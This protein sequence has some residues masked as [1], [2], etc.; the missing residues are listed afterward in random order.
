MGP[1]EG[2]GEGVSRP[3]VA[4]V[5][6]TRPEAIKMAPVYQALARPGGRTHPRLLLTGQHTDLVDAALE[7]FG[8][9][10]DHDM[11][12]MEEGQSLYHVAA[13]CLAGL[14]EIL[15]AWHP[16]MVLVQGDTAT[17]FFAALAGYF[18]NVPTGHV[19]AGLRSGNLRSPFPEEGFR[20]LTGVLADLHFAPTSEARDNLLAEGVAADRIHVTGNPVVD[21]LQQVAR[22]AREP[23]DPALA[24][25]L[26]RGG[27]FALLTAHRRESFGEPLRR[28]FQGVLR[29]LEL[30]PELEI[31]YPVHPNPRVRQPAHELLGGHPRI[32]LVE[33]LGYEDLVLALERSRVILT[34]SGGIQ[35]EA[36]TFGAPVLVLREVTE[37]PEGIRAGVAHLVGTDPE[38]IVELARGFLA[39]PDE[40]RHE[41]MGANPY[42]DGR[43]GLRIARLVEAYL[44]G[45]AGGTAVGEISDDGASE[46]GAG[47][48]GDPPGGTRQ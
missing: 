34:D 18:E 11:A 48:S 46:G 16:G 37:R 27:P 10:P 47:G 6:G 39:E 3:T 22:Q 26:E 38:R 17:V 23:V 15:D 25:L 13:R 8:L 28:V 14:K 30:E 35:E 29:L 20:R 32:H 2:K 33:P 31:F 43:A 36:P 42:G 12:L 45:P 1:L 41:R 9:V 40:A 24:R 4:V 5:V 19:E 44:T 21:A 7:T